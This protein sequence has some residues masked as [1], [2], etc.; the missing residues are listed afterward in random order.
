LQRAA[1]LVVVVV[2]LGWIGGFEYVREI[3][4]KP[5]LVTGYLYSHGVR[6]AERERIERDGVLA[7][8]RWTAVRTA[9]GDKSMAAGRE[10]FNL[11]CLGC[12]TV[13]G[14]RNDIVKRTAALTYLGIR[15]QL[16]GQGRMLRYMPPVM[17]TAEEK[18]ALAAY[19]CQ[20]GGKPVQAEPEVK[21]IPPLAAVTLEPKAPAKEGEDSYVLLAWNDFGINSMS[22]SDAWFQLMPPANTLEAQVIRGGLLPEIMGAGVELSY[23]V[24]AGLENPA[25]H[26]PFW[27]HAQANLG[28]PLPKNIGLL[29]NGLS[30]KF[31]Y[32]TNSK[33]FRAPA[34]PVVPY[35]DGGGYHPYPLFTVQAR[36]TNSGRLLAEAKVVAPTATELG[37]RHCHGGGW[38][39]DGV[40]GISA[41]TA[42]NILEAHDRINRTTLL[43]EA[44]AGRPRACQSCHAD[45]LWAMPGEKGVLNLSAAMHGWHAN[46][47]ADGGAQACAWCHPVGKAGPSRCYRGIHSVLGIT[48]VKCH[49]TMNDHALSL[50]TRQSDLP[51]AR[52]LMKHLAPT[53]V[54]TQ[55]EIKGRVP[56]VNEPDCL[57]CHKDFQRPVAGYA[58]Y[59]QWTT[60]SHAL[61][62]SRT[63]ERGIRC[64]AC[65]GSVH[66]EYPSLNPYEARRDIL[67]PL[68]YSGKPYPIASEKGCAVCHLESMENSPHHP[69]MERMFRNT[70]LWQRA[71]SRATGADATPSGSAQ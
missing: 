70:N 37:C 18:D 57:N 4:R 71:F 28:K 43:A 44:R 45:S 17:G 48:C 2:G 49:G 19:L 7:A 10:M 14:I 5:F 15:A 31:T 35:P 42:R 61:Y 22:D 47:L 58:A 9:S 66:A 12:H 24:E 39:R 1:V 65:H 50:L 63:D 29:G 41:E 54:G 30:G 25:N 33:S 34:I 20:L 53:A 27:D 62:R 21:P 13:G 6:V 8:A 36:E 55:A 56:W 32:D 46:Y 67:Q 11:Q 26:V 68:H 64:A 38:R 16:E 59:N 3:A 69:N 23:R 52:E 51:A 60:N 40:A